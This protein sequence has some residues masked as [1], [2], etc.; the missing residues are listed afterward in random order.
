[1]KTRYCWRCD[2][3]VPMLDEEEFKLCLKAKEEGQKVVEEEIRKR[4][5]QNYQWLTESEIKFKSLVHFVNM[6]RVITGFPETNPNAIWHH[7]IDTFGPDCP[8]CK[9]PLRTKKAGYCVYCGLGKESMD[10]DNRP[11]IEKFKAP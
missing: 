1:M 10:T 4:N 6:Y 11:L 3:D 9:K 8:S 7:T 2:I 5:I